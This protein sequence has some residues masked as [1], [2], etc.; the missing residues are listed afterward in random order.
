MSK[1]EID[2]VETTRATMSKRLGEIITDVIG[3]ARIQEL[4]EQAGKHPD[5]YKDVPTGMIALDWGV[6]TPE[7][8]T[9]LLVA[10][11][12]RNGRPCWR[13]M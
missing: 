1:P 2:S 12:P 5:E 13:T 3:D 11:A 10:Q 4:F 6:I 8:K 7:T 9:A